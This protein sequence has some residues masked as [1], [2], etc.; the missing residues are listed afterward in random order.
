MKKLLGLLAITCFLYSCA[1]DEEN[2]PLDSFFEEP[3]VEDFSAEM[4]AFE[5]ETLELINAF[6]AE[7]NDCGGEIHEPTFPLKWHPNL[8]AAAEAHAQYMFDNNI[9]SHEG[10]DGSTL[11]DRLEIAGYDARAFGENIA[12][13]PATP[14]EVVEA[15]KN[16]PSH[17][18]VMSSPHFTQ[19]GISK[20][21]RYWVFDFGTLR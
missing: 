14:A 19:V 8:D 3:E 6:R 18:V 5:S 1:S 11:A 4:S 20:I 12:E 13:G 7:T 2:V 17:C 10:R 15:F 21:G 16:S 9:L